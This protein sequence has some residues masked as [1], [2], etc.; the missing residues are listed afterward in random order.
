M[1][2]ANDAAGLLESLGHNVEV[3]EAPWRED[4]L[5]QAFTALFAPLVT[6]QIAFGRLVHG[7]EPTEERWSR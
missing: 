4:T 3:A 6:L 5:L 2:A 7:R 1:E